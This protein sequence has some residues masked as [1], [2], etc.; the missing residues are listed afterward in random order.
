MLLL[1]LCDLYGLHPL[2][3]RTGERGEV[4]VERGLRG[5]T[6]GLWCRVGRA[7]RE[8]E[9]L[10]HFGTLETLDSCFPDVKWGTPDI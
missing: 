1:S 2:V 9:S 8:E 3:T 5:K 10:C 4:R 6:S 7:E